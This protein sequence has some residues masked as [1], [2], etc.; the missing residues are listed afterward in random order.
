[1]KQMVV[2]DLGEKNSSPQV[3]IYPLKPKILSC[4]FC[5]DMPSVK[6]GRIWTKPSL[7]NVAMKSLMADG[8]AKKVHSEQICFNECIIGVKK[9]PCMSTWNNFL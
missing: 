2:F 6:N 9:C 5:G 1:M 3:N 8:V 7:Q 4:M